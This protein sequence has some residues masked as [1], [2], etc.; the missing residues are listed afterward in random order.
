MPE[1]RHVSVKDGDVALLVGTMKGAFLLRSNGARGRW[2]TAGPYFPGQSIYAL[3]LDQR[4]GR[5][6]LFAGGGDE[7]WGPLVF[8]SDD[9][10]R[11]WDNPEQSKVKFPEGLDAAVKR[12]WQIVPGA[13][14]A[15]RVLY[16]GVEPA[17]LFESRDAG[18]TWSLIRGLWDHPHRPQWQPGGGG[19]CLHTILAGPDPDH[20]TVA[21]STGGVYRSE[22][23]GRSWQA[24]NQGVRAQFL[25]DKHP[26]FGQC[27]HKIVRHPS[28]PERMFLQNHW[29]LYRTENAGE[30][31]QDIANGVPSDFGFAMAMHPHD[32]DT[33]YIVPIESD[34]FR[35]TPEGKLRVYRTRDG[36]ES[37]EPLTRGLPQKNALE[38]ILRDAMDVDE[39]NPAGV[40]F[41]TRSGSI[42]GSS[43]GGSSWSELIDGLPAITCVK[44]V[45]IGD[46]AKARVPR[47]AMARA[48]SA[49]MR[50]TAGARAAARRGARRASGG[51]EKVRAS[52]A[53]GSSAARAGGRSRK[54][55]GARR[56]AS[57][58][59]TVGSRKAAGAR[60]ATRTGAPGRKAGARGTSRK[61]R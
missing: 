38:T 20:L 18:A 57:P 28:R 33:V 7:H 61:K 14:S 26:E 53:R 8:T 16:A 35:C 12:V 56:A 10:G 46:P 34:M 37:W 45:V 49:S 44:A 24:R 50:K 54:T 59:K 47:P 39:L 4:G 48:K 19:L 22:D 30:S 27:V 43:D 6:R 23:S 2:E 17:A 32:P 42:W 21:I 9:F 31:W 52:A 55:A 40:Y 1:V 41:G 29:G 36:G 11:T 25:P 60:S 13:D 3:A 5:R 58:R 51:R 15:G